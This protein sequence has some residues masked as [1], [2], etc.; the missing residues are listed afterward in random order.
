ME[1]IITLTQRSQFQIESGARQDP[2]QNLQDYLFKKWLVNQKS[3]RYTDMCRL[4]GLF[5]RL[6]GLFELVGEQVWGWS[7]E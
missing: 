7:L 5:V 3:T 1:F 2:A 6:R 4:R